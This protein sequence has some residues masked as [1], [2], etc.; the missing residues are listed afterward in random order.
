MYAWE[1]GFWGG[2]TDAPCPVSKLRRWAK[3]VA[4]EY[5]IPAPK[6]SFHRTEEQWAGLADDVN[7]RLNT[8]WHG[9]CTFVLLHELAHYI[10]FQYGH[11]WNPHGPR[12]LGVYLW[13]LDECRLVPLS[14]SIPSARAAGLKF[15]DPLKSCP[16]T[17]KRYLIT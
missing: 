4:K 8:E 1:Q 14:A 3:K 12:F 11:M 5:Q 9:R 13:L 16:K 2:Y 17:L 10:C 7:I 6:L 15:R